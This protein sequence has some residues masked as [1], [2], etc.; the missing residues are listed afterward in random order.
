MFSYRTISVETT[1]LC[2]GRYKTGTDN[3]EMNEQGCAIFQ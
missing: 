2:F 3:T 1:Q